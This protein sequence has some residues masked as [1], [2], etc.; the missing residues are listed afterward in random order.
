MRAGI[1]LLLWTPHV[2]EAHR[3]ILEQIRK[4]GYDGVEIPIHQGDPADYAQLG[5]LIHTLGLLCTASTAFP[6][7]AHN[8][9]SPDPAHRRNAVSYLCWAIDCCAALGA[10]IL[11]GPLYQALGIFSGQAPTDE[12]RQWAAQVLLQAADH[13]ASRDVTLAL[14]PLNRFEAHL[15]NTVEDA[16]TFVRSLGHPN[17][18]LMFDTF[19]A[20]IEERDPVG[21]L[22]SVIDVLV[23]VH[24]SE[25]DRGVPGW[26]HVPFK[27]TLGLLRHL[28]YDGWITVEAFGK[29]LPEL[30]AATRVWR[31]LYDSETTVL[32]NGLRVIREGWNASGGTPRSLSG[33][34]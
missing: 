6:D 12:E 25:N 10:R 24:V 34:R 4:I 26:G 23:H 5:R 18:K 20:N 28:G 2:T 17:I 30:A 29:G 13:A 8:P 27:E 21:C 33:K 3:P 32:V 19:H 1:N 31:S 14:E 7:E 16:A 15:L 9:S 11:A 22:T